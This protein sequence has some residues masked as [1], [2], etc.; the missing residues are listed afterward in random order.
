LQERAR[1]AEV[2]K[3]SE[4]LHQALLNSVSHE[5]RTPLT[6]IVGAST[7]LSD[8]ATSADADKKAALVDDLMQSTMRLNRIVENLLDMSRINSGALTMKKEIFELNDFLRTVL[9]SGVKL[10]SHH[11]LVF[12][13]SEDLIV[14]GDDRLLEHAILNLLSNASQYSPLGSEIKITINK[15]D[16]QAC[17]HI[18][19]EGPGIP[20]EAAQKIFE[21]FYRV[22]GTPAGGTGLGLSIVKAIVEANDGLVGFENRS[23]RMGT[24]FTISLPLQELPANFH[25]SNI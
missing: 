21:R 17:I 14:L 2:L 15:L 4:K 8:S 3:K 20:A 11:R 5:L 24:I 1:D 6:A 18:S 16:T 25:E 13:P 19:D 12:H 22:P 7:A 10:W 23:D 9:Q